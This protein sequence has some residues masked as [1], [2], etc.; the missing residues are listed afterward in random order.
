MLAAAALMFTGCG[1]GSDDDASGE[2]S[3]CEAV[4]AQAAEA[5]DMADSQAD[6]HPAF[7]ECQDV[8]EFAAAASKYPQV[9]DGTDPGVW[10]S[11][12]CAYEPE[13]DGTPVCEDAAG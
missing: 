10:I 5:G 2:D 8:A 12:Q 7:S 9:L 3:A 4:F 1:G 6:L 11:N 13:L